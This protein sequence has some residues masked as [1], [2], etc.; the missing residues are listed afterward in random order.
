MEIIRII[1]LSVLAKLFPKPKEISIS[2]LLR[3]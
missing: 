2:S 1:I 3:Y